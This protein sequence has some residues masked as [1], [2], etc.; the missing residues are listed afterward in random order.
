MP[1]RFSMVHSNHPLQSL[2][3]QHQ[4]NDGYFDMRFNLLLLKVDDSNTENDLM[5]V[6]IDKQRESWC[7][8]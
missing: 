7:Q 5:L 2:I 4:G 1:P 3:Q 6:G 8:G